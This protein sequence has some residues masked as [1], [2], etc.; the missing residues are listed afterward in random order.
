MRRSPNEPSLLGRLSSPAELRRLSREKLPQLAAE[1]REFLS[2]RISIAPQNLAASL[3]SVELAIALHYAYRTPQDRLIWDGDQQTQAHQVLTGRRPHL[4]AVRQ[5]A[6]LMPASN[7]RSENK[8][9]HFAVGHSGTSI[10]AALGMASAA[11]LKGESR[12]VVAVIG[13]RALAAGMAFEALN[14]AGSQPADLLVI[15]NDSGEADALS[16]HFGRAFSGALYG[17][18]RESGK[19]MLRQMPTMREL[20]RRS[21]KHV[22]GMLLPGTLFEEIG[23]NYTGPLDGCDVKALVKTLQSLQRLRGRQFLHLLTH[24]PRVRR[25]KRSA[26][27]VRNRREAQR[28]H[29][30]VRTDA[31]PGSLARVFA[32]WLCESAARDPRI[33][34]VSAAPAERTALSE[35]ATRFPGRYFDVAMTEQHAVTFA[36]GLAAEGRRPVIALRSSLLQRG[37]DQL[38]HD[39]ALQKLPV[40]FAID[41]AGLVDGEGAAHQGSF[42]LSYLR[43]IPGLTLAVPADEREC[44]QLLETAMT[45]PG[46]AVVRFPCAP[47]SGAV[48]DPDPASQPAPL[49]RA[50]VRR[51]GRSGLALLVFGAPLEAARCVAECVDATLISMRFV[52]PL[53]EE[54]LR[55][56]CLRHRALVSIEENSVSGGA[57]SAVGEWLAAQGRQLPL[58]QLG[59]ADRFTENGAR[60]ARLAAAGLDPAGL[61]RSVE[62]FWSAQLQEL[63]VAGA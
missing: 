37:Y 38:V 36:A 19:R 48:A 30:A 26:P 13:D 24:A 12:R 49:G 40:L 2:E 14:H 8:Y 5:R 15:L 58:L 50:E 31:A 61:Q 29:T 21:E 35:F 11:A 45:L 47:P 51:E 22:K 53:D 16:A 56:V 3:G 28:P 60:E 4:H 63:R 27:L 23:F 43:C 34:C 10:S 1:L 9:D 6:R 55:S 17:Q 42:D 7:A 62:R 39:V 52:K 32:T 54:L 44:R 33:V 20:A 25:G 41:A 46:P 57:G 59:I 18:L